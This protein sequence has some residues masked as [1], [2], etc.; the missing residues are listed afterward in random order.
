[1]VI[2]YIVDCQEKSET[3]NSFFA[4]H[5]YPISNGS[6]LPFVLPLRTDNTLYSCHVTKDDILQIINNL[7]P[8][9]KPI[10]ELVFVC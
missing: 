6:V 9:L 5:C 7:D 1:M 3:F 4:D 10:I 2:N 8:K